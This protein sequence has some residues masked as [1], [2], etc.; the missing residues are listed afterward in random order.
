MKIIRLK[1]RSGLHIGSDYGGIGRERVQETVHSDT[2]FSMLVNA[3]AESQGLS[4]VPEFIQSVKVISSGLPYVR[5]SR[6]RYDYFLPRPLI[7]PM[8][9]CGQWGA[10]RKQK[11][12]KHIKKCAFVDRDTFTPWVQGREINLNKIKEPEYRTLFTIALRPQHAR[13][14]LT[15]ASAIYHTGELFF[16]DNAGLY[17]LIDG[18][19]NDTLQLLMGQ[20][21]LRGLGGRRSNGC[22]C[23]NYQMEDIDRSWEV[24]LNG[25]GE[26][27]TIL[28]LFHPEETE[29]STLNP[30]AYNLVQRKGWTYSAVA[31]GQFK[32][33]TCHMFG[34]GSVF[35]GKPQG[36]L[37]DVTPPAML[38]FHPI[39]RFGKAFSI[40]C[41]IPGGVS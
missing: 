13:D 16:A 14:R 35:G 1:F 3:C 12:H 2:L 31:S 19:S 23:F 40:R 7:D 41:T 22:G 29:F 25:P 21:S 6:D 38:E 33:K 30:K 37:V 20:A 26:A 11:Y 32:R 17:F 5:R 9:F 4:N 18:V 27:F 8:N 36:Q 28:S 34:E 39:Y 24:L 15:Y 10:D